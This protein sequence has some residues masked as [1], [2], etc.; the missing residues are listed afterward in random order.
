[1]RRLLAL[2]ALLIATAAP[3]AACNC[4]SAAPTRAVLNAYLG[5]TAL[6]SLVPLGGLTALIV[7]L[8]RQQREEA[9]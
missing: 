6:L 4:I 5:I 7:W 1:M 9:A 2:A 3:A 8:V